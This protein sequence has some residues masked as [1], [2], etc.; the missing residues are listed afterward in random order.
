MPVD[1]CSARHIAWLTGNRSSIVIRMEGGGD[2]GRKGKKGGR[3]PRNTEET[4]PCKP[5]LTVR[6][7]DYIFLLSVFLMLW[8]SGP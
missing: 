8:H 7:I 4:L 3:K 6:F 5:Q 1:F 2:E